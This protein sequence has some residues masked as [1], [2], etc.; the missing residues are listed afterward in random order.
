MH[1]KSA[2][3]AGLVGL[4]ALLMPWSAHCEHLVV[5]G[6][7]TYAPVIYTDQGKPAGILPAIFARLSKDT[8]DTYEL[9]LVPW[10]R[11][12]MESEHARGG[13]TNISRNKA[14]EAFY[15]FSLPMY[16]D[17]IQLVVLKGKEFDYR[18]LK[19]LKGKT[20]GGAAGA[21][22]G[23]EVDKAIAEGGI[24]VDRDPGQLSRMRKLL[25]GRMDVAIVGN[26]MVGLELLLGSDPEL[27]AN[28]SK[29]V[30]LPHPLVRDPLHLAFAK[31]MEKK[32][33]LE[34]FNKALTVF[35]KSAEYRKLL[36]QSH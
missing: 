9:V 8:G 29:F 27:A 15:D 23:D 28:R 5:Y 20:V 21:S 24:T 34:R 16:D 1:W 14:R 6:D 33:A 17:D 25:A 3:G 12:L 19:D 32:P 10:K 7:E 35:K 4:A 2:L 31:T 18:E 22:Y 11:A 30:V 26:G 13:I 36:S